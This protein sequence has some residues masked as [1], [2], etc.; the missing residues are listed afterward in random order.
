M[1]GFKNWYT[2]VLFIILLILAGL[3]LCILV[4]QVQQLYPRVC[5]LAAWLLFLYLIY[6]LIRA[7]YCAYQVTKEEL[8]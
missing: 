7:L 3:E 6:K 8:H 5:R 2:G 1:S 4:Y